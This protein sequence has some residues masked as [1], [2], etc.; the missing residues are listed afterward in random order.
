MGKKK[1]SKSPHDRATDELEKR[2]KKN[3]QLTIKN[4]IYTLPFSHLYAGELDLIGF[5]NWDIDIY[6]VKTND[7]DYNH[8][9]KQLE[10]AKNILGDC[11]NKIT[12]FYYS[13]GT[14]K[15]KQILSRQKK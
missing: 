4:L 2:V 9:V 8:A 5:N 15:I 14:K 1:N 12:I 11:A 3:Y 7:K 10:R 6:E 13:A